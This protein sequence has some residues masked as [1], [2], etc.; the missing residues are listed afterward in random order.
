MSTTRRP[1][2]AP[3][4]LALPDMVPLAPVLGDDELGPEV[5][6]FISRI[7]QWHILPDR[8]R[9][10]IEMNAVLRALRVTG[11]RVS[12]REGVDMERQLSVIRGVAST[13]EDALLYR[14][15]C[16]I[17]E[18]DGISTRPHARWEEWRHLAPPLRAFLRCHCAMIP[19]LVRHVLE[20]FRRWRDDRAAA[21]IERLYTMFDIGV[22]NIPVSQV[23]IPVYQAGHFAHTHQVS[24]VEAIAALMRWSRRQR[25]IDRGAGA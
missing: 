9:G 12:P 8:A 24:R 13:N 2:R 19:E 16:P 5:V 6:E 1:P 23:D 22:A 10:A 3:E 21:R 11:T 14:P 17:R 20:R 7:P 4:P 25:E 15:T 18:I